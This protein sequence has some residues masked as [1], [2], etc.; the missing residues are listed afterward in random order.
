MPTQDS[1][2]AAAKKPATNVLVSVPLAGIKPDANYRAAVDTPAPGADAVGP[3]TSQPATAEAPVKS[4]VLSV[5]RDIFASL[6]DAFSTSPANPMTDLVQG[7]YLWVRRSDVSEAPTL[8]GQTTGQ[9]NGPTSG[10]DVATVAAE[11]EPQVLHPEFKFTYPKKD[12][13]WT[14]ERRAEFEQAAKTL[15]QY[16]VVTKPTTLEYEVTSS[17]WRAD[18]PKKERTPCKDAEGCGELASAKSGLTNDKK[19]GFYDTVVQHKIITG[20]DENRKKPDGSI[21][22]NFAYDWSLGENVSADQ[23]DFTATV[24]HELLHTMGFGSELSMPDVD[25]KT[26][27]REPVDNDNWSTYDRFLSNSTGSAAIDPTN[28]TWNPAFDPNMTGGSGGGGLYFNGSN[29]QAA[30][31]EQPVPLYSP[32]EWSG[33][34]SVSHLDDDTFTGANKVMMVS[35]DGKGLGVRTLSAVEIAILKDLGYT[36]ATQTPQNPQS[37]QAVSDVA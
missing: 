21:D 24:M 31:G 7:A 15:S 22:F 5:V 12:K 26:G 6:S 36:V 29:A 37:P 23:Y 11:D 34:S 2:G 28:F 32:T 27:K 25:K 9:T 4:T 19:P 1:L 3:A 20:V 17:R 35:A 10:T 14:P 30:Y 18:L 33:G 13:Y 16:I 8:M